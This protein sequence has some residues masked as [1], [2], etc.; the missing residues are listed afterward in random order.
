MKNELK[1]VSAEIEAKVKAVLH[2]TWDA[3]FA[4]R[5]DWKKLQQRLEADVGNA[6]HELLSLHSSTRERQEIYTEFYKRIFEITG[7]PTSILDVA[8]G[9]NPLAYD[10]MNLKS[11]TKYF[12]SDI[13]IEEIEFLKSAVETLK[14][15]IE[16]HFE[17]KDL[18]VDEFQAVDVAFLF[19]VLQPLEQQKKGS[20]IEVVRKI[21]VKWLVITFPTKSISGKQ[22][23][24]VEFYKAWFAANIESEIKGFEHLE[25]DSE[26]VYV[27]QK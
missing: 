7:M 14:P 6:V 13:D 12:A 19:K 10:F 23:G 15:P 27:C 17:C 4:S 3:Y 5:P 11:G 18:I 16:F 21:N 1:K 8:C 26:L 20:A 9:F 2:Q 22:K 25:F 24:M